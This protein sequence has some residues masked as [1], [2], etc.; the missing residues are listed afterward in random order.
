MSEHTSVSSDRVTRSTELRRVAVTGGSVISTLGHSRQEFWERCAAGK[1]GVSRIGRFVPDEFKVHFAGEV[2]DFDAA[3]MVD[4]PEKELRRMDRFVQF[5]VVAADR[6]LKEAGLERDSGDATRRGVLVGSGIG[7]LHEI[8]EQ[9]RT[10]FERGPRRVSPFMIPKLMVNAASGNISYLYNLKGPNSAVATACAS[11]TNAIGDAFRLIQHG[12]A[13]VM[14][15]GGSEAAITPMGVSGF[16]RMNALSNRNDAPS[17]ASRPFDKDRDGFVLGE[18]AGIMI[19][20]D[21]EHALK[22]GA[23]ILAEVLGYG[24]SSDAYHMTAPDPEGRGAGRAMTFAIADAGLNVED[25]QYVNAH[26]TS[27]PLGDK[28]ET[29]AIKT[30]FGHHAKKLAVSSTKSQIGHLLGASGGVE[31]IAC[32]MALTEQA[33]PPT[34]N[35]D[36]PGEGCDLDYVPHEA[37]PMPIKAVLNNSFGF[38]GHNACLVLGKA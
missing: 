20:E 28:A 12:Q 30:V 1:S 6:A 31:T 33:A 38:G 27:T 18:G 3:A 37:R 29:A 22:R 11:A 35:L 32:L 13:D 16:A 17:L 2:K 9:H 10:L 24:M 14:V 5:A 4:V 26:G 36:E 34:I 19:L 25:I 23:T 15:T 7:G 21:W 8:E